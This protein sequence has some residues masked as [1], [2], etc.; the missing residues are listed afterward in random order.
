MLIWVSHHS[1]TEKAHCCGAISPLTRLLGRHN[2]RYA[3]FPHAGPLDHRTVRA[4]RNFQ[5]PLEIVAGPGV[6]DL[7]TSDILS[8]IQLE[9][10]AALVLDTIKRGEDDQ[11]VSRAELAVRKGRSIIIRIYESLGGRAKG[12]VKLRNILRV[13][14]AYQTNALEDDEKELNLESD[15]FEVVLRGFEV[16]TFRLQL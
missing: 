13:R 9:G 2:I 16:A 10:S 6:M 5:H 7:S 1:F 4:A 3:I 15:G 11:D 12:F 14:A 8:S